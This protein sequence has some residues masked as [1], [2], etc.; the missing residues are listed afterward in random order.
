MFQFLGP[1]LSLVSEPVKSF[2]ETRTIKAENKANIEQ[3]KVNAQIKQIERTAESE[4]NYDI[5][6]LRQQQYSWKDEF[7]LLVITFPF[8]GSFLPWTQEFV[9]LGWEYVSKAP[10][11]YSY[12]FIGAISASLGIRWATKMF[13]KK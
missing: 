9:M 6:A 12:T 10:E 11:W 7:A 4:I 3:A 8:I 1:I 5:E 13:G 2:M